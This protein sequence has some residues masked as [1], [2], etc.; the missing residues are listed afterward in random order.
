MRE[1]T[2]TSQIQLPMA[3]RT[4][5]GDPHVNAS[6]GHLSVRIEGAHPPEITFYFEQ[7]NKRMVP[8]FGAALALQTAVVLLFVLLARFGPSIVLTPTDI[9]EDA[10]D[11]IVWLAS[12]GPGG[13]GGGGGNKM[14]EPP[15]AAE[16]PGKEKITVPAEKP[17]ALEPPKET[18]P[19]PIPLEQ[20]NI[21]AMTLS[22]GTE[23]MPGIIETPGPP[24]PSL[25]SGTG[26][27]AGTGA[28]SGVG[29]GSGSGLGPGTGGGTGGGFYQPGNGVSQPRLLREVKPAYTSD[30]MRAKVQGAVWVRCVVQTDGSITNPE[31]VRSLDSVFGLD[32]EAIKA[33][34]QWRF[35]PGT[36][37]GQPVPVQITIE[38]TFNLR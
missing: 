37:M 34:R 8:A 12:P 5:S 19:E 21:P 13:G 26:S 2:S 4:P 24:S 36:R 6:A 7:Q 23:S 38:L 20:L 16:L 1:N 17:K 22:A 27:G 9:P 25:G 29:S 15:R 31:V 3:E 32:Q 14:K 18:K 28:G 11:R 10:S 33:V 35:A 30:A